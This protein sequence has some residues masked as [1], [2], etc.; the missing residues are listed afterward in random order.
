MKSL[1]EQKIEIWPSNNEPAEPCHFCGADPVGYSYNIGSHKAWACG[2][3]F[4]MR[5][6]Y[7]KDP[8]QLVESTF[9]EYEC[10]RREIKE[11]QRLLTLYYEDHIK[12]NIFNLPGVPEEEK[13][14]ARDTAKILKKEII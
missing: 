2:T 11:L 5:T 12:I 7:S 6:D 3:T 4:A 8:K 10:Y 13:Q 14:L 1:T 9:R